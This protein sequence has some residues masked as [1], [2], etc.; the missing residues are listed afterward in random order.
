M[1]PTALQVHILQVEII[2]KHKGKLQIRYIYIRN[3]GYIKKLLLGKVWKI[4]SLEMILT[5]AFTMII[6]VSQ[7]QNT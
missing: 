6:A 3:N 5:F 1:I 7:G 2:G 4:I